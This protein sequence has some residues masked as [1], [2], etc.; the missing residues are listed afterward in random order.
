MEMVCIVYL[1]LEGSSGFENILVLTDHLIRYAHVLPTKNQTTKARILFDQFIVHYGFSVR[2]H[3]GQ[4]QTFES[5]LMKELCSLAGVD[6]SVT[7]H[8]Y[9]VSK[10]CYK[11]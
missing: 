11:C 6:K 10:Y 5:N 2:I 3:S 1:S 9:P 7:I 8:H 4:S